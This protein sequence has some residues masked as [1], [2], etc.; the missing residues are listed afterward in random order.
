MYRHK[1]WD[2]WD[3]NAL[4]PLR[5]SVLKCYFSLAVQEVSFTCP[6]AL[7]GMQCCVLNWL[8][9]LLSCWRILAEIV[10]ACTA[11]G[12]RRVICIS[13]EISQCLFLS[14]FKCPRVSISP[15]TSVTVPSQQHLSVCHVFRAFIC[16]LHRGAFSMSVCCLN[17]KLDVCLAIVG[18]THWHPY[19]W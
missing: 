5:S 8:I 14:F 9:I 4:T 15:Q 17:S 11:V 18:S 19:S 2:T 12:W 16:L 3:H 1:V 7:E 10:P 6:T 13:A